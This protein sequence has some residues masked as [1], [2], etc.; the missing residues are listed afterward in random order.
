MIR[1][2]HI[3][4]VPTDFDKIMGLFDI[5]GDE[6]VDDESSLEELIDGLRIDEEDFTQIFYEF[7][8]GEDVDDDTHD[9]NL[10]RY[11]RWDESTYDY[12]S[13]RLK[14]V[15]YEDFLAEH[16]KSTSRVKLNDIYL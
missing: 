6:A 14:H 16:Q 8:P 15:E 7:A 12:D 11:W 2:L 10:E 13:Y 4:N 9:N 3:E 5:L 1:H